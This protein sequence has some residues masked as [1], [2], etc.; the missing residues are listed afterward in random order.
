MGRG[1][2]RWGI[3]VKAGTIHIPTVLSGI[4]GGGL[5]SVLQGRAL[6]WCATFLCW[7]H[8]LLRLLWLLWSSQELCKDLGPGQQGM[9]SGR[10]PPP[11]WQTVCTSYAKFMQMANAGQ[12]IPY[13]KNFQAGHMMEL[14]QS[15]CHSRC[16]ELRAKYGQS[17]I[18]SRAARV[19]VAS[20]G[21]QAKQSSGVSL[22]VS[23]LCIP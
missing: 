2:W 11:D 4:A 13:V 23:S 8:L 6:A 20:T 3:P 17:S 14:L 9:L 12:C 15:Q 19:L 7:L 18:H 16:L 1:W 21:A 10:V 22:F 5:E